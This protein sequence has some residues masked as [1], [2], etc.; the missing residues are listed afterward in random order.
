MHHASTSNGHPLHG[1]VDTRPVYD[2]PQVIVSSPRWPW[3]QSLTER[4]I[5]PFTATRNR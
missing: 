3:L 4:L 2:T 5:E 1:P